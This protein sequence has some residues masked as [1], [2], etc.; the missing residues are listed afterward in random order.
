[1]NQRKARPLGLEELNSYALK[2]LAGRS[3]SVAELR[4]RLR[5][6]AENPADV[7]TVLAALKE[8]Q[9]VD[10]RRFAE[11]FA[12]VRKDSRGLGRQR[13]LSDLLKKRVAPSVAQAAVDGAYAG[14][15]EGEMIE[16]YLGRKYRSRNL[17]AMLKDDRELASVFRRLRSAG[18][19]AGNS[20]RV[21]KRYAA[22]ADQIEDFEDH[23]TEA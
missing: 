19:S 8:H 7:S 15:D 10:D 17:S 4:D 20:I 18:F 22:Q 5:K 6:R 13:A 12:A 2:L 11:H 16:N 21:L 14:A 1:M 3:L 9:F 23:T